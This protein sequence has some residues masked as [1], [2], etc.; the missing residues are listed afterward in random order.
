MALVDESKITVETETVDTQAQ[1][2]LP[3][4]PPPAVANEQGCVRPELLHSRQSSSQQVVDAVGSGEAALASVGMVQHSLESMDGGGSQDRKSILLDERPLIKDPTKGAVSASQPVISHNPLS[5]HPSVTALRSKKSSL[6][7]DSLPTGPAVVVEEDTREHELGS[8]VGGSSGAVPGYVG[9]SSQVH[10]TAV[11]SDGDHIN[12]T[13]SAANETMLLGPSA[14]HTRGVDHHYIERTNAGRLEEESRSI[15][16]DTV[17]Q[18]STRQS[19]EPSTK[20]DFFA[21]RLA[22]AVGENEISDSEETFVYESTA[23]ST[24]N[25]YEPISSNI[26]MK[27]PSLGKPYGIPVKMSTPMLNKNNKLL[28]RLKTT[29]HSSIAALPSVVVDQVATPTGPQMAQNQMQLTM[30]DL[31]SL[32]SSRQRAVPAQQHSQTGQSDMQSVNSIT[33]NQLPSNTAGKR[34]SLLSLGKVASEARQS[35]NISTHS[36]MLRLSHNGGN[37]STFKLKNTHLYPLRTTASRIFDANGAS[38]R[39]YS[40]VPDD[41]NL[42]DYVEQENGELTPNKFTY[43][44]SS[45]SDTEDDDNVM[46]EDEAHDYVEEDEDDVHSMFYYHGNSNHANNPLSNTNDASAGNDINN[47][48]NHH[49]STE[50][51]NVNDNNGS[52]HGGITNSSNVRGN[53]KSNNSINPSSQLSLSR[54]FRSHYGAVGKFTHPSQKL[55][56]DQNDHGMM[57]TDELEALYYFRNNTT[58]DNDN[59]N[60]HNN[61]HNINHNNSNNASNDNTSNNNNNRARNSSANNGHRINNIDYYYLPDEYSPLK[62][63]KRRAQ[64]MYSSYYNPHNFY[65]RRSNW[66]KFKSFVYLTFIVTSLLAMGFISGFLLAT[67]KELHNFQI[68]MIN[69]ILV[70]TDELVFDIT[71]SSFNPGVFTVGVQNVDLDIFAKTSHLGDDEDT[72][73]PGDARG[74]AYQT[75]L[76]GSVY[77]LESPLRFQGGF[78]KRGHYVAKSTVKLLHPGA[79]DNDRDDSAPIVTDPSFVVDATTIDPNGKKAENDAEKWK[80]L[81]RYEF[82]LILRGSMKYKIPLFK[83]EKSVVVQAQVMVDPNRSEITT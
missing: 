61:T 43:R 8:G 52:V 3:V 31:R 1:L 41:I 14:I 56:Y 73:S 55:G 47:T 35:R 72:N 17:D 51:S 9:C 71:A 48:P 62:A 33:T 65:T 44:S 66:N 58:N 39:R 70:S 37:G 80:A 60:T 49:P 13:V 78:F 76:L 64:S 22:S 81:I 10:N 50:I 53:G 69:N 74:S 11:Q 5:P 63:K 19:K 20:A 67:N 27:Q 2:L 42:E 32:H 68:N 24:K 21:A 34:L 28:E 16:E 77:S 25:S 18:E 30:D 4:Q 7:I 26:G 82:E 46:D 75:L 54:K 6:L 40:G 57:P 45:E 79:T 12:S 29:R 23:N 36:G 15:I 83:S 38:L 59:H